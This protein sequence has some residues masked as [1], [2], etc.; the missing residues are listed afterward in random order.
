[1]FA[2]EESPDPLGEFQINQEKQ[3]PEEMPEKRPPRRPVRGVS[4]SKGEGEEQFI[5]KLK[6]EGMIWSTFEGIIPNRA[7]NKKKKV[8]ERR[9][10]R[11]ILKNMG[12]H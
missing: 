10:Q 3:K 12:I 6:G 5:K 4:I 11:T 7:K 9:S 1:M 2:G 8:E